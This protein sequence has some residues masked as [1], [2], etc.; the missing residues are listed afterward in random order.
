M[1][2]FNFQEVEIPESEEQKQRS[3][4]I[5][6]ATKA[7]AVQLIEDTFH[8]SEEGEIV[9]VALYLGEDWQVIGASEI[10]RGGSG[11]CMLSTASILQRAVLLHAD[12]IMLAHNHPSQCLFPSGSDWKI[13][14]ELQDAASY[15]SIRVFDH[16]IFQ[17]RSYISLGEVT[18]A[19][20]NKYSNIT[21]ALVAEH[22][23]EVCGRTGSPLFPDELAGLDPVKPRVPATTIDPHNPPFRIENV[24]QE[25]DVYKQ[26]FHLSFDTPDRLCVLYL[27]LDN[28]FVGATDVQNVMDAAKGEV[29]DIVF[30]TALRC[31]AAAIAFAYAPRDPSGSTKDERRLLDDLRLA[32]RLIDIRV[33]DSYIIGEEPEVSPKDED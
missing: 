1:S 32:A 18:K 23:H 21:E 12:G 16:V 7:H 30:R 9:F 20:D 22:V 15:L 19:A 31:N 17:G 24:E 6:L 8:L 5:R 10:A 2:R 26:M 11:R 29:T 25:A 3:S 14:G 28:R 27:T 33:R 13:T 4:Q